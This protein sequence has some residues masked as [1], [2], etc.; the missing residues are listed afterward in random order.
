MKNKA[1]ILILGII[2]YSCQNKLTKAPE[3]INLS[4]NLDAGQYSKTGSWTLFFNKI[5][6]KG[7]YSKETY[8]ITVDESGNAI[9]SLTLGEVNVLVLNFHDSNETHPWQSNKEFYI[10]N[11]NEASISC[12]I[13]ERKLVINT[14]NL[15]DKNNIALNSFIEES[16][17]MLRDPASYSRNEEDN[18]VFA[19]RFM[20]FTN[21]FISEN[22]SIDE[23]LKDYLRFKGYNSSLIRDIGMAHSDAFEGDFYDL[24]TSELMFFDYSS[25]QILAKYID[26]YESFEGDTPIDILESKINFVNNNI[27]GASFKELLVESYIENFR[28]TY[29]YNNTTFKSDLERFII[30]AQNLVDKSQRDEYVSFFEKNGLTQVGAEF[31]NIEFETI[32]GEK[33]NSRALFDGE[34]LIYIDVWASWCQPCIK[35][36]PALK[37]LDKE[38]VNEK[39]KFISLSIDSNTEDWHKGLNHYDLKKDQYLDQDNQIGEILNIRGIPRFLLYSPDGELILIDAPRPSSS[40][41]RGV[42]DKHL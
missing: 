4:F 42:L 10:S 22:G 21:E 30:V 8:P 36:I 28:R 26:K 23:S 5:D 41:I 20:D 16:L 38:Y 19:K 29:R 33:I 27:S 31:P 1:L 6:E 17:K 12:H 9:M 2:L 11:I 25:P 35:E 7:K 14:K 37:E 32:S 18:K 40:E 34:N 15:N 3:S 24:Y 39:V 13:E